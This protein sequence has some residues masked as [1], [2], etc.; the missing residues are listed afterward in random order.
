MS[1]IAVNIAK[2]PDFGEPSATFLLLSREVMSEDNKDKQ[3]SSK[4][5]FPKVLRIHNDERE[6]VS[7]CK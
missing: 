7:S 2:L 5:N 3:W 6:N 1:K 4:G